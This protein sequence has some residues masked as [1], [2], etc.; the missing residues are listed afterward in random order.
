MAHVTSLLNVIASCRPSL[1]GPWSG[2]GIDLADVCACRAYYAVTAPA[3]PSN[4]RRMIETLRKWRAVKR[5]QEVRVRNHF[6]DTL[7]AD[8]I[9]AADYWLSGCPV[10]RASTQ[11]RRS[12]RD[13]MMEIAPI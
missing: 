13:E 5:C 11:M 12:I 10:R 9:Q 7:T 6:A 8:D 4:Q 2:R 3:R 1:N